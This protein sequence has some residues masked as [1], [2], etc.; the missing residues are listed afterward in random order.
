MKR[1]YP[2]LLTA[3]ALAAA[4]LPSPASAQKDD[5]GII[6]VSEQDREMNGAKAEAKR[7]L[8]GFLK[9]LAA[10]PART[11]SYQI[12]YP[13]AGWEY[14]WVGELQLEGDAIVG[15]LINDPEEPG[16]KFGQTVRV[17]L[18]DVADWGYY[19]AD[20]V[21]QGHYTTRVLLKRVDPAEA[22][23]IRAALGWRE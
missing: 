7:T 8:P 4:L 6:S 16:Y 22:A 11:R 21:M 5:Y 9:L 17:P 14:I 18:K 20:G 19:N 15:T 10:P 3:A 23:E 12:K 2:L 1:S 13:L